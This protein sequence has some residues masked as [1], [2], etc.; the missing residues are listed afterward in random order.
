MASSDQFRRIGSEALA[1]LTAYDFPGNIRELRNVIE[2]ALLLADGEI[3]TEKELPANLRQSVSNWADSMPFGF[4]E[5]LP[6]EDLQ[7]RYLLMADET[8]RGDR[9]SLA[10]KLGISESSLYRKLKALYAPDR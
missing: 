9:K 3:I 5:I 10:A 8:Y 2:R 6:L 1:C 7:R 4:D